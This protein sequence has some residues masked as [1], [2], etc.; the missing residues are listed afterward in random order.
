MLS[1]ALA[2]QGTLAST[3]AGPTQQARDYLAA[4]GLALHGLDLPYWGG[5][6][7]AWCA[8]HTGRVPPV[9]ASHPSAWETWGEPMSEPMPDCVAVIAEGIHRHVGIIVRRNAGRA[10]VIGAHGNV[11][12]IRRVDED[13]IIAVRKPPGS[14]A[15][16]QQTSQSVDI[17]VS[18]EREQPA[19][20]IELKA[21]PAPVETLPRAIEPDD[22]EGLRVAAV[23]A[24][25]AAADAHP[26]AVPRL[27]EL[28][29]LATA[30]STRDGI[31]RARDQALAYVATA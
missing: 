18:V 14:V 20:M 9:G 12:S 4:A 21:V 26:Q 16:V 10:Y 22:I 7:L 5:A 15:H 13:R 28:A 3:D 11:V 8:I 30:A 6:F 27:A 19:N 24:M 23:A 31:E 1:Q 29:A 17:R 2:A 25:A